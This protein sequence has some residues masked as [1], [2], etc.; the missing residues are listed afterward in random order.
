MPR[1]ARGDFGSCYLEKC[2]KGYVLFLFFKV[3]L[4]V[5]IQC[6]VHTPYLIIK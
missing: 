5:S 3:Y 6:F 2:F 4:Y 1:V